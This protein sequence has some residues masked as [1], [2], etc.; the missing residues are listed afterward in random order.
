[1]YLGSR[2]CCRFTSLS[3]NPT[4]RTEYKFRVIHLMPLLFFE[5]K[6]SLVWIKN[7]CLVNHALNRVHIGRLK[8]LLPSLYIFDL[9]FPFIQISSMTQVTSIHNSLETPLCSNQTIVQPFFK[10]LHGILWTKSSN[11]LPN[12]IKNLS[13]KIKSL[14][15]LLDNSFYSTSHSRLIGYWVFI[16]IVHHFNKIFTMNV[17]FNQY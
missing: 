6:K 14:Q 9:L 3:S 8:I 15:F 7:H 17:M 16:V 4:F 2:L 11:N 13:F 5:F 1:M 10:R 12:H